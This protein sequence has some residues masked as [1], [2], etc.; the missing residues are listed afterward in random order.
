ML[1][2]ACG[3]LSVTL[4]PVLKVRPLTRASI[5]QYC[6]CPTLHAPHLCPVPCDAKNVAEGSRNRSEQK[7]RLCPCSQSVCDPP[8]TRLTEAVVTK[9]RAFALAIPQP[10]FC[11]FFCSRVFLSHYCPGSDL[12]S[13][14][15]SFLE[16][17]DYR[18]APPCPPLLFPF[19]GGVFGL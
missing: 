9:P 15:L 18:D 3:A 6:L 1:A 8:D 13:A 4:L 14:C 12:Q 17:L 2:K 16:Y 11:F 5:C 7:T 19:H 10:F